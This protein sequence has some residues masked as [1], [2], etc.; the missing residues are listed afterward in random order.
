MRR[1]RANR[2]WPRIRATKPSDLPKLA[3]IIR[4][5]MPLDYA[6]L[7]PPAAMPSRVEEMVQTLRGAWPLAL[8]VEARIGVAGVALVRNRSHLSLLW[9]DLRFR[10]QGVG[11]RLLDEVEGRVRATG[12]ERMTLSVYQGN[13]EAVRFYARRGWKV[14]REYTGQVGSMMLDME[15]LI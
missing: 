9:L 7:I 11:G 12:G 8:T 6:G 1:P 5:T 14:F 10:N 3:A 4:R 13:V 2:D 15:K